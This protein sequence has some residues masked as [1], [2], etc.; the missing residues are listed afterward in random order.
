MVHAIQGEIE[1]LICAQ[2]K[3]FGQEGAL[4]GTDLQQC[5][6][7]FKRIKQLSVDLD[8]TKRGGHA[9]WVEFN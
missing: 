5:L 3:T 8:R 7:R 2:L 9:P 1:D 6:E 4:S